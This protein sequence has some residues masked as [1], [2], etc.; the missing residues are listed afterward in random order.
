MP[1]PQGFPRILVINLCHIGDAVM[2]TAALR[3]LRK[4][5]PNAHITLEVN[6]PCASLMRLPE[7]ADK[8]IS[9]KQ[10]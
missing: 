9:K 8:I 2:A 4:M 6:A 1:S 5:S 10:Y 3:L 7:L